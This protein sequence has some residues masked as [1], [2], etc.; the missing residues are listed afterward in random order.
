[1]R[2]VFLTIIL[3]CSSAFALEV[4]DQRLLESLIRQGI[5][6]EDQSTIELQESLQIYLYRKFSGLSPK[7]EHH[8]DNDNSNNCISVKNIKKSLSN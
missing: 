2:L 4:D 1:M 6:C 3:F 5:I 7:G 8:K